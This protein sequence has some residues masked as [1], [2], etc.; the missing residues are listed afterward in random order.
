MQ[1]KC[2]SLLCSPITCLNT[3]YKLL[4]GM[5]TQMLMAHVIVMEVLP[6][7]Q[8]ALRKGA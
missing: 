2:H 7:E 5:M 3:T 1:V 6:E 4:T 8:K